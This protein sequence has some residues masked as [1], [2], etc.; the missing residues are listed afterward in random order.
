MRCLRCL[1]HVRWQEK[2]SNTE[3][4]QICNINSIEAFL[5]TAQ[6]RWTGH[7][8]HMVITDYQRP[9]SAVNWKKVHVLA[10][11][12]ESVIRKR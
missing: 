8:L 1:A 4:L 10:V 11:D 2:K 6:L 7:V 12:S 5:I 9:F 3:V